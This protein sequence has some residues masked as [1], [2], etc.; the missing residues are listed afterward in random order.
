MTLFHYELER[1]PLAELE[2]WGGR[3]NLGLKELSHPGTL[4]KP[5]AHWAHSLP[6][7]PHSDPLHPSAQVEDLTETSSCLPSAVSCQ[8]SARS[9]PVPEPQ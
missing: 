8:P 5:G 3:L 6:V 9:S 1:K 2:A 7:N 4:Q